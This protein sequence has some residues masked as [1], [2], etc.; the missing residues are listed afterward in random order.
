MRKMAPEIITPNHALSLKASQ[1]LIDKDGTPRCTG[2]EWLIRDIGAYLPGVFEEVSTWCVY[3]STAGGAC[4]MC[5]C[6]MH[7]CTLILW[8]IHVH[9]W[10]IHVGVHA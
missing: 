9:L 8:C 4:I 1:N 3:A 2:E 7:A 10:C 5:A 6:M